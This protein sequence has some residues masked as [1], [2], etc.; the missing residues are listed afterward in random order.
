[1]PF[2]ILIEH[3]VVTYRNVEDRK[4]NTILQNASAVCFGH[5][6]VECYSLGEVLLFIGRARIISEKLLFPSTGL[7]VRVYR[8]GSHRTEFCET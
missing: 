4:E 1:M 6:Q 2:S 5:F 7:S 3:P 8:R